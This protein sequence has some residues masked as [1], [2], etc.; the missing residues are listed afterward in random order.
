M[1]NEGASAIATL[2]FSYANLFSLPVKLYVRLRK[3]I[4]VTRSSWSSIARD[5]LRG[6]PLPRLA[7][8]MNRAG[9]ACVLPR[10]RSTTSVMIDAA[11]L[12]RRE[13]LVY[14]SSLFL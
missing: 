7:A 13:P 2:L 4:R 6:R 14:P 1:R 11:P 5:S 3:T 12:A 10:Q 8:D 9:I